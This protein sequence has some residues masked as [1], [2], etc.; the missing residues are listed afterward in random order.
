[1]DVLRRTRRNADTI[2]GAAPDLNHRTSCRGSRGSASLPSHRHRLIR[3]SNPGASSLKRGLYDRATAEVGTRSRLIRLSRSNGQVRCS[4]P[5]MVDALRSVR[6][7]R[8]GT[9]LWTCCAGRAGTR[10]RSDGAAPDLNQR[11]SCRG[12]RGSASLPSHRHRL[13]RSSNPGASSL[14]RGLYDRATAEVGTRSRLIRLSRSNGQVRCSPPPMVD[15]LRSVRLGRSGTRLWTCCAGR[16][17]TRIRST[18][19]HRILTSG[20]PA[21]DR[22]GARPYHPIGIASSDRQTQ[23][24]LRRSAVYTTALR[25]QSKTTRSN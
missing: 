25:L 11:T 19:L 20:R 23:G 24:P 4:P 18:A 17:G 8:S 5:P 22:A 2:R 14:K 9:R 16:A 10:I 12:S 6:L 13:I 15:A 3:S 21:A 1:M 7:G